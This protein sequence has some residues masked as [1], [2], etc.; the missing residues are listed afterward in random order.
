MTFRLIIDIKLSKLI[1]FDRFTHLFYTY[2]DL[3]GGK[4]VGFKLCVGSR[5][6][7]IALCKAM[8]KKEIYP[9]LITVDGGEGVPGAAPLEY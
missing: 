9:A 1:E 3:S 4:P 7:F 6:E 2:G 5:I 8:V